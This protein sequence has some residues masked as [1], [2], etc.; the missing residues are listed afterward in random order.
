M[1]SVNNSS[2]PHN[3]LF[4]IQKNINTGYGMV[5]TDQS[6]WK[7]LWIGEVGYKYQDII[8]EVGRPKGVF[9]QKERKEKY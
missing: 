7:R 4:I 2:I 9:W 8:Q 3:W 6:K 1:S 5:L